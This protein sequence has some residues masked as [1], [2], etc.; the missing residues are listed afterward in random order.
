MA[1]TL[2]LTAPAH[3]AVK[4][5][6]KP[7][8]PTIA[9]ITSSPVKKGKVNLTVVVTLGADNGG[10]VI[11]STKI[12][13]GGKSCTAKKT[14]TTCTIK[15]IKNGKTVK[16]TAKSKNRKGF[17]SKS[18]SISYKVGGKKWTATLVTAPTTAPT[19]APQVSSKAPKNPGAKAKQISKI[20][21]CSRGLEFNPTQPWEEPSDD[22][23]YT[24]YGTDPD[25]DPYSDGCADVYSVYYCMTTISY[26]A[27][28]NLSASEQK[29]FKKDVL[30]CFD[31]VSNN[32]E[33]EFALITDFKNYSF[34][35]YHM[36]D[37]Q[38]KAML[39]KL[40]KKYKKSV[41]YSYRPTSG[42]TRLK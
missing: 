35:T 28:F 41:A 9:S 42:C 26:I 39:K 37:K 22:R 31:A 25:I 15:G 1:L 30:N 5:A 17:G 29:S 11:T 16:V 40:K 33:L 4:S 7:S 13:A 10:A 18:S 2:S 12:S 19:T 38:V 24:C 23:I 36:D 32:P 14:K 8:A 6:T 34:D 27:I 21:S 20:V 3:A